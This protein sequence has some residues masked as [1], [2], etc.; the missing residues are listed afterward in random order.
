MSSHP[1]ISGHFCQIDK[2]VS[3]RFR[4]FTPNRPS[5]ISLAPWLS[6][7]APSSGSGP[8][9]ACRRRG[10]GGAQAVGPRHWLG[11]RWPCSISCMTSGTT[12]SRSSVTS[13]GSPS[14]RSIRI[15]ISARAQGNLDQRGFVFLSR[16]GHYTAL[17]AVVAVTARAASRPVP[18]VH[19]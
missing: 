1:L 14:R 6:S 7:S 8:R 11:K 17:G 5:S 12:R 13:W 3:V 10:P 2:R 19:T 15:W 4:P 9:P 16:R 18:T